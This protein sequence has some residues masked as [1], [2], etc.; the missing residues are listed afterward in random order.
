M[1]SASQER[2][3]TYSKKRAL[4]TKQFAINT[5]A[6]FAQYHEVG[7]LRHGNITTDNINSSMRP[8][9]KLRL[10]LKMNNC[11]FS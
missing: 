2:F 9:G 11:D 8:R 4:E 6:L 10:M 1:E 3:P 7:P 5:T